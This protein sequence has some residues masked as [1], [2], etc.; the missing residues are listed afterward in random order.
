MV[1]LF[2]CVRSGNLD[3]VTQVLVYLQVSRITL[4]CHEVQ[5]LALLVGGIACKAFLAFVLRAT[6]L[7]EAGG[8]LAQADVIVVSCIAVFCA[9]Y[10]S[11]LKHIFLEPL[12]AEGLHWRCRSVEKNEH[13]PS[14]PVGAPAELV[15]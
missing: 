14:R 3:L 6:T 11:W 12:V 15:E 1:W 10:H 8:V 4:V 13:C 9:D 2:W 5:D 7:R